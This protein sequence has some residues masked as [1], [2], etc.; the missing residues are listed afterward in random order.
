MRR[1]WRATV[2]LLGGLAIGLL[3]GCALFDLFYPE[4]V[5]PPVAVLDVDQRDIYVGENAS[6]DGSRSSD[7]NSGPLP[8]SYLWECTPDA[9][10]SGA[11]SRNAVFVPVRPQVYEITLSVSDGY[12]HVPPASDCSTST[13]E[14]RVLEPWET[15]ANPSADWPNHPA[16]EGVL[17]GEAFSSDMGWCRQAVPDTVASVSNGYLT[18]YSEESLALLTNDKARSGCD[19]SAEFVVPAGRT[20]RAFG[21]CFRVPDPTAAPQGSTL[22]DGLYFLART[23]NNGEVAYLMVSQG[24]AGFARNWLP[25]PGLTDGRGICHLRVVARGSNL[26]F[27]LGDEELFLGRDGVFGEG[28]TGLA[29][30]G[31]DIQVENIVIRE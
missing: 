20:G 3:A 6:L 27:F 16:S 23:K 12:P 11:S 30:V 31:G 8:L 29:V 19:I 9:S 15:R 1:M 5:A 22:P 24:V 2:S 14:L 7:P 4:W 13:C 10:I 26:R 28:Y 17:Y 18:M 21:V 25:C